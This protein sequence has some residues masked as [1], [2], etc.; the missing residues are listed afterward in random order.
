MN[1]KFRQPSQTN[2]TSRQKASFNG[3]RNTQSKLIAATNEHQRFT[4]IIEQGDC[5]QALQSSHATG[6]GN[7][8]QHDKAVCLM[9]LGRFA[10]AVDILRKLVLNHNCVCL[11]NDIPLVY[12]TNFATALLLSGRPGGCQSLLAELKVETNPAAKMARPVFSV[13]A[14]MATALLTRILSYHRQRPRTS[15]PS[16]RRKATRMKGLYK[17]FPGS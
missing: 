17:A 4:A 5:N 7:S 1:K 16:G 15:S 12:K 6:R 13:F 8:S 2:D 10:E 9:R 3:L 11:R 14:L